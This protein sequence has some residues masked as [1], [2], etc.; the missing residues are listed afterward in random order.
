LLTLTPS[1]PAATRGRIANPAKKRKVPSTRASRKGSEGSRDAKRYLKPKE[2]ARLLEETPE[3]YRALVHIMSRVGLRSGEAYALRVGKFDPLKRTLLIDTAAAG[4][5]APGLLTW[6]LLV[7]AG[8]F[9]PPTS[10][11]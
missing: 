2:L 4:K 9:E 1:R 10:C 11:V 8:G 6:G 5:K 7:G 3:R